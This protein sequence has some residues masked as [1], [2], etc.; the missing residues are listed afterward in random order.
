MPWAGKL[1][2]L[3]T[4]KRR[5]QNT[6]QIPDEP[7]PHSML[8]RLGSYSRLETGRKYSEI[9]KVRAD[10]EHFR[11]RRLYSSKSKTQSTMCD[12]VKEHTATAITVRQYP[13]VDPS[14]P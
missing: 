5:Q 11:D 3:R 12:L 14:F 2:A 10:P 4:P 8:H 7:S 13:H 9:S 1:D 6:I